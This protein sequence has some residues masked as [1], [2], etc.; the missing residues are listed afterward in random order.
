MRTLVILSLVI[1]T[2]CTS[3]VSVDMSDGSTARN[4]CFDVFNT[5]ETYAAECDRTGV[6]CPWSGPVT[7]DRIQRCNLA[8]YNVRDASCEEFIGVLRGELCR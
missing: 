8:L 4:G 2:A 7:E 5:V 1:L 6:M 3:P